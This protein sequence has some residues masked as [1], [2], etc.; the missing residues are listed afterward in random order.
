MVMHLQSMRRPGV[1]LA[2][3]DLHLADR[4]GIWLQCLLRDAVLQIIVDERA[5]SP[6]LKRIE[7]QR[8]IT[9][10]STVGVPDPISNTSPIARTS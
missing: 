7:P 2:V 1:E 3:A 5:G 9:M 8:E 6:R 10:T 4:I